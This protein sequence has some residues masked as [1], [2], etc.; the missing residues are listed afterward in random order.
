V[1]RRL[2]RREKL[3]PQVLA[4]RNELNREAEEARRRTERDLEM[5]RA[6]SESF[7]DRPPPIGGGDGF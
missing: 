2:F 5:E 6:K 4:K 3:S 1:L 7:L